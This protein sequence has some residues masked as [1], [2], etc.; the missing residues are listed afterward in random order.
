MSHLHRHKH[1][2]RNPI[3]CDTRTIEVSP[4]IRH[5]TS[6]V[7]TESIAGVC[8]TIIKSKQSDWEETDDTKLEFIQNKPTKL[9]EFDNDTNFVNE[10]EMNNALGDTFSWE[11]AEW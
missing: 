8:D 1:N 11:A 4:I 10:D 3:N 9:S 7:P 2:H 5:N 6:V